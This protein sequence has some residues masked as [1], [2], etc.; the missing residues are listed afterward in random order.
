MTSQSP[1]QLQLLRQPGPNMPSMQS[2]THSQCGLH[3]PI[4]WHRISRYVVVDHFDRERLYEI[5]DSHRKDI[6][7]FVV[8]RQ[9]DDQ[10]RIPYR[11][12]VYIYSVCMYVCVPV[13]LCVCV[14]SL[15]E[16]FDIEAIPKLLLSQTSQHIHVQQIQCRNLQSVTLTISC[17]RSI[18][19]KVE[20]SPK[21]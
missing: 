13:Y 2:E 8:F 4:K 10:V 9:G 19:P 16:V 5:I 17:N 3:I 18:C 20:S 12:C 7:N 14:C 11:V 15:L 6:S 1:R 21:A